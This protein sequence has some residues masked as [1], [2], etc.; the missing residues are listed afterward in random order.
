MQYW[1]ELAIGWG[2]LM[3]MQRENA[4]H[5]FSM[6]DYVAWCKA[7]NRALDYHDHYIDCINRAYGAL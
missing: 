5:W 7:A 3:T 1:L 2:D 4:K 6:G